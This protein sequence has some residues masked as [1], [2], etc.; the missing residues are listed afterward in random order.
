MI[1]WPIIINSTQAVAARN[2]LMNRRK[3]MKQIFKKKEKAKNAKLSSK[4]KPVY[5]AKADRE[6]EAAEAATRLVQ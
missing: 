5:I 1:I 4:V 6:N 3:K 2:P